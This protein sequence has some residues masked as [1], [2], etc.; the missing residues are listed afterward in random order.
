M[1]VK[2]YNDD[3]TYSLPQKRLTA[4]W[5]EEVA[6]S[7]GYRLG[8]VTY[9]F[10]SAR[11]LLEMNRQFLGHDYFTDIIT[12]DY[13]DRKGEKV[14][15]GDIFIDVETVRDNARI[16]GAT[17]L[18]EMRR[19][20]VHGVLHLCGQKDKTPRTNAQMHRKEDK[21]LKFW[22]ELLKRPGAGVRSVLSVLLA[23]VLFVGCTGGRPQAKAPQTALSADAEL[24]T[25][26]AVPFVEGDTLYY[27][28]RSYTVNGSEEHCNVYVERN[29]DA[30]SFRRLLSDD[31]FCRG[32]EL[33]ERLAEL[34]EKVP[35]SF[36]RH[37]RA[38]CPETWFP[39]VQ[40][41]G[42]RYLD[43]GVYNY[44]LRITDSLVEE[45]MMDGSRFTVIESFE[46]PAPG[47]Y[48]IVSLDFFDRK[49]MRFDLYRL[50]SVRGASALVVHSDTAL[51]YRKLMV[52]RES[53]EQYDLL[54]WDCTELPYGNEV[55]YDDLDF[56]KLIENA[57][58]E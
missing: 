25:A 7:E 45:V 13:S 10:C 35:L 54:E 56:D 47:H 2:Y 1:A 31:R 42:E 3:C 51:L 11:R 40:V 20:V 9:V 34:R 50:D 38:G 22:D 32:Q 48:R 27:H 49:R 33:E 28:K 44:P 8:D 6:R 21:Y 17:A 53:A 29:R 4:R 58:R 26:R 39:L 19:V 36:P 57:N 16:Y 23:G 37:D 55:A 43:G 15:S 30:E 14:V 24:C 46:N 41:G 52:P 18:C 12:F 5:L